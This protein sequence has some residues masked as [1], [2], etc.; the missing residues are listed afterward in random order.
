MYK[1]NKK[2]I[3]IA[4]KKNIKYLISTTHPNNISSCKSLEK[5]GMQVVGKINKHDNY[6]RNIFL[7]KL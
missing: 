3:E 6:E 2:I 7:R 4:Y 1:M 5:L